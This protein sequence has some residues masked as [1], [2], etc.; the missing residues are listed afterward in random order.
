MKVVFLGLLEKN[1]S[2]LLFRFEEIAANKLVT[3]GEVKR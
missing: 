3:L 2:I 1:K